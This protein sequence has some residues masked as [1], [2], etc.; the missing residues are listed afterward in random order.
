MRSTSATDAIDPGRF[1]QVLGHFPTGVA[2]ITSIGDDGAPIG[3]TVG[4]FTS[5]SLDPPLVAFLPDK[6]SSTFP[7]IRQ[8][9]SFCVNVL[10]EDQERVCRSLAAKGADKFL[11]V[12]WRAAGSGS[13]IIGGVVAWIDCDIETIHDAGDH[14]IVIGRVRELDTAGNDLPLLFFQGGYGEFSSPWK[15]APGYQDLLEPLRL[16][17]LA[18]DD[19]VLAARQLNVECLASALTGGDLVILGSA[20]KPGR[21][22]VNSIGQRVPFRPPIG[23]P[24]IAWSTDDEVDEWIRAAEVAQPEVDSALIRVQLNRVRTR[25]W[26]L[27]L[28]SQEQIALEAAVARLAVD[29]PTDI[30]KAEVLQAL[31]RLAVTDF[32]EP[33]ELRPDQEY[34]VRHVS[35]PVFDARDKVVLAVN[36]YGLPSLVTGSE[37]QRYLTT[38]TDLTKK[39]STRLT[40]DRSTE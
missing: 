3:M 40:A 9:G 19:M 2:A 28:A 35:A 27:A 34:R 12:Q 25:G 14:Y 23:L 31:Q 1:R 13:P 32:Y 5:V 7:K 24:L 8:A 29:A 18:R 39:I 38:L 6:K 20:S 10:G 22:L 36:L 16:V 15:T 30:Q 17:D 33:A 37:L 21:R 4:S 26:S 11:G